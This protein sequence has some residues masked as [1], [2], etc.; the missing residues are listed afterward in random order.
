MSTSNH[1]LPNRT[2]QVNGRQ[3]V[4]P[5][6]LIGI[7]TVLLMTVAMGNLTVAAQEPPQWSLHERVPGYL[8]DTLPPYLVADRNRT[9]HAFTSQMI[10]EDR[11]QLVIVYRQWTLEGGWTDPVDILMSPEGEA[12]LYGAFLD[13]A[14][15]MHVMFFGG[16]DWSANIYYSRA[17]AASAGRAQ[18]WSKPR[19][20]GES[21]NAP[22]SAALAGDEKGNLVIIYHGD[23]EGNGVYAIHSSDAGDSWSE[24]TPIFLTYDYQLWPSGLQ[25]HMGQSGWLHAVWYVINPKGHNVSAHYTRLEVAS[26][27]WREPMELDEGVGIDSGMG[28]RYASVIEY[29]GEVVV[30]Y[31]N[32]IPPTGVPPAYW[33]RL[34]RDAGQSWTPRQRPFPLHIGRNGDVSLVVD[35]NDVLHVLFSNRIPT[36]I[37][38][39]Y[40]AFGGMFHSEFS[41][42]SWSE[43]DP[44]SASGAGMSTSTDPETPFYSW[45]EARAV[46]SQGNVLLATWRVDPGEEPQ[47]VWYSY[48]ILDAPELPV[49][50][51]PTVLPTTSPTLE[52]TATPAAPTQT[53]RPKLVLAD[54][55]DV[56]TGT[57]PDNPGFPVVVGVIPV[58]LLI[59]VVIILRR[60][61]YLN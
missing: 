21:A 15:M 51:L 38:G 29:G 43:P 4:V 59:V 18:A 2:R 34:S 23:I 26:M 48:T 35:S 52:P 19:L 8:D 33:V 1:Q 16:D 36:T 9:V 27:Q 24:P 42:Y 55:D 57:T 31:N 49:E 11:P 45:F 25:M 22:S 37:N 50:P 56:G 53:P 54:I 17:P 58:V 61:F 46:I 10:G 20:V 7:I 60:S 14:G 13:E 6:G 5:F 32:G 40:A 28:I 30:M 3:P 12:R 47:G 41:G 39:V 44:V